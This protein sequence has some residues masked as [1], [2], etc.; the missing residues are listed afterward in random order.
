MKSYF[1]TTDFEFIFGLKYFLFSFRISFRSDDGCDRKRTPNSGH[2]SASSRAPLII[3]S[4]YLP[5]EAK[6]L[7]PIDVKRDLRRPPSFCQQYQRNFGNVGNGGGGARNQ[8]KCKINDKPDLML[9]G[10]EITEPSSTACISPSANQTPDPGDG[11]RGIANGDK[12]NDNG[13]ECLAC[14][15]CI[16]EIERSNRTP[17][18]SSITA[19]LNETALHLSYNN[20]HM[21]AYGNLNQNLEISCDRS[22]D[23]NDDDD[24]PDVSAAQH[25]RPGTPDASRIIRITLN[26]KNNATTADCTD[27]DRR[28]NSCGISSRHDI[29]DKPNSTSGRSIKSATM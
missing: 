24:S 29:D 2:Q 7:A 3:V 5:S 14:S 18:S 19:C 22:G 6:T 10:I 16:L 12:L 15:A 11:I 21:D 13:D 9:R 27:D 20:Y 8:C 17:S 4:L 26:N 23:D 25:S 1:S 28:R